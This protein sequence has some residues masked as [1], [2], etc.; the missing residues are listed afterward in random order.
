MDIDK[1]G[2]REYFNRNNQPKSFI[3]LKILIILTFFLA[4]FITPIVSSV[5]IE[6]KSSFSQGETLLAVFSGT[7][8]DQITDE[9]VFFYR[10]HVQIP[11]VFDVV[12]INNNFYVYALL[13]G[14]TEGNYSIKIEDVRYYKATEIVSEDLVSNFTI[15]EETAAFSV[16]PGVLT[17]D[18]DF[19]IELQNLVDS[20]ITVIITTDSSIDFQSTIN[21]NTGE[22]KTINFNL[23]ENSVKGLVDITF[24]SGNTSYSM[25]IYL[26]TNATQEESAEEDF[27]MEFQPSLVS[28][29]LA[30]NSNTKRILYLKNTGFDSLEDIFFDISPALDPYITISPEDIGSLD[31]GETE[32]I[33]ITI[34]SDLEEVVIEGR[35]TAY[36]E[37]VSTSFILQLDFIKDFVSVEEPGDDLI[38]VTTCEQ[39][40]GNICGENQECSGEIKRSKNGDCCIQPLVCQEPSKGFLKQIIGWLILAL[41]L[42]IIFWFFKRKYRRVMPRKPF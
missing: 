8:V 17:T 36:T 37:N 34:I 13:T 25:P 23:N 24:S 29:S 14:K 20:S 42:I 19:S 16:N 1:R 30:T 32:Q 22:R 3:A 6:M 21:L 26:N 12:K 9:N 7:F 10:N 18:S 38:I 11:M 35:V 41:V 33:E 4:I 15:S 28:V 39:L 2:T 40:G 27:D 5:E 31:S